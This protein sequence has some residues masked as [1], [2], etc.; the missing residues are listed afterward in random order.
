M[1]ILKGNQLKVPLPQFEP[2]AD[3]GFIDIRVVRT[4]T[5]DLVSLKPPAS[6]HTAK[7]SGYW[8]DLDGR[9]NLQ[10][11]DVELYKRRR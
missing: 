8:V 5:A 11:C 1:G 9:S 4:A 7:E 3:A 2:S 6:W 10:S